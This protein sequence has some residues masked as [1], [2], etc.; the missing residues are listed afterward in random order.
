FGVLGFLFGKLNRTPV[1]D[2][3]DQLDILEI[4]NA[5][6]KSELETCKKRLSGNKLPKEQP[7]DALLGPPRT[8]TVPKPVETREF[9]A[10]FGR[11]FKADDLKIVEGIGPKIEALFH[12]HNIK[13]WKELSQT[14]AVAARKFLT[15][16]ENGTGS[17]T[18][19][20]GRCRP[21]WPIRAN[22]NNCR[23]GRKGT[24]RANIE[25]KGKPLNFFPFPR[26]I[27]CAPDRSANIPW[28]PHPSC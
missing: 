8:D 28:Y 24:G 13:S 17:T 2:L 20:P 12:Q 10:L 25:G 22:G 5:K 26:G 19:L 14:T 16:A 18:R 23:N 21:K 9:K 7:M 6:L 4:E 27:G 3:S 11:A 15:P 1:P